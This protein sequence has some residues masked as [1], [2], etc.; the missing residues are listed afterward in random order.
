MDLEFVYFMFQTILIVVLAIGFAMLLGLSIAIR[1]VKI[2]KEKPFI[3]AIETLLISIVPAIPLL[4]FA[5]SRGITM[6]AALGW[7]Y[8]LVIKFGVF[9]ILLQLSG[10][11]TYWFSA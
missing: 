4:F 5:V 7:F 1:D 6:T 8:G 11:Y 2:M 9:H 10:F 3:F